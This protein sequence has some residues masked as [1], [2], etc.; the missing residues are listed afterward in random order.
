MSLLLKTDK[1]AKV[2]FRTPGRIAAYVGI[3]LILIALFIW[4]VTTRMPI[5]HDS[6]QLH[7]EMD[8]LQYELDNM[9]A[10]WSEEELRELE[11]QLSKAQNRIF[12][13]LPALAKW[14]KSKSSY[15][16][17]LGMDMTYLTR[18][19]R[20]TH[21]EQ[22]F[23]LPVQMTLKVRSG[24]ADKAY[25]R[26][27]EFIRSLI[28]ENLHLEIAGNEL[29]SDGKGVKQIKLYINVWVR[30]VNA[31]AGTSASAPVSNNSVD[32]DVPFIQ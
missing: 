28:D 31:I 20:N 29:K 26:V 16:G 27:L 32:S 22:T 14:L 1:V 18:Q 13:D 4:S 5:L 17:R 3:I 2:T 19:P 11:K 6:I 24:L 23:S 7:T 10:Q 25:I 9:K 15:A 30:D 12:D 21:L 8:M